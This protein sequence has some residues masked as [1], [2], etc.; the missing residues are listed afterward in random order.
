MGNLMSD[1]TTVLTQKVT[2]RCYKCRE[3]FSFDSILYDWRFCP[4]HR[5]GADGVMVPSTK[6]YS[7]VS[8]NNF[9]L[10]K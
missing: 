3:S 8:N 9:T 4:S 5:V 10:T 7:T 6:E 2:K 1:K